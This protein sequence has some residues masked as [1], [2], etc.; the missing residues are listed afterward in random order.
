MQLKVSKAKIKLKRS[1]RISRSEAIKEKDIV[2]VEV[3]YGRLFGLG[4]AVPSARFGESI[5]SVVNFL[6][7]VSDKLGNDPLDIKGI[8]DRLDEVDPNQRAAK[9]AIDM[10]LYDINGKLMN[11]PVYELLGLD[12]EAIRP[13]AK[14]ISIDQLKLDRLN[15]M[16]EEYKHS[17]IIKIKYNK[18]TDLDIAQHV[19]QKTRAKI[20]ID[21]NEDWEV[22][23]AIKKIQ[24][25]EKYDFVE[26]IEQPIKA[27]SKEGI[28]EIKKHCKMPIILDEDIT[29]LNDIIR[30]AELAD[31]VNIK[32]QKVGGIY[33][34]I[35]M[36][37]EA[38]KHSLKILLGCRIE[39][40]LGIT[41]AAHIM[42]LADFV[43]LDSIIL[44]E[45]DPFKGAYFNNNLLI[46]P[47]ST[48]L[49][50]L[51]VELLH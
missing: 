38:R 22:D 7:N 26:F 19:H 42:P 41:A 30:Y 21:V 48:G 23:E 15:I 8:L 11:K 47:K 27:G 28:K 40:S 45:E 18:D 5:E 49:G 43:D 24:A 16:C 9:A 4:E 3:I 12:R 34:A 1:W 33:K 2:L 36:I 10:A 13:S 14:T 39:S 31:G 25:L 37:T 6:F 50:V 51:P 35:E 20:W 29:C 32:I 46:I 17:P 44:I